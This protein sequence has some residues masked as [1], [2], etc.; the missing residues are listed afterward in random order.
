MLNKAVW[1]IEK[2]HCFF[3]GKVVGAGLY[4][5]V[6]PLFNSL[7][8]KIQEIASKGAVYHYPLKRLAL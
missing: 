5:M 4:W 3:F 8:I 6:Q 2:Q 1:L 7:L